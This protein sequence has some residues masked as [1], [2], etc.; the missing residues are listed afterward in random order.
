MPEEELHTSSESLWENHYAGL[1]DVV[2]SLGHNCGLQI[3]KMGN[4]SQVKEF[5]E[6]LQ[7]TIAEA[8]VHNSTLVELVCPDFTHIIYRDMV[9]KALMRN[10]ALQNRYRVEQVKAEQEILEEILDE[11][12]SGGFHRGSFGKNVSDS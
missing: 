8:M 1:N 7:Q 2:T 5:P 4:S 3:L 9:E 10:V 12:K 6:S 11:R